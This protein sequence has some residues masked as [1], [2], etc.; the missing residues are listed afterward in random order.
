MA[1][2]GKIVPVEDIVTQYQGRWVAIQ[3]LLTHQKCLG[4][5]ART[6]LNCIVKLQASCPSNFRLAAMARTE[7]YPAVSKKNFH[8]KGFGW[9]TWIRTKINGVRVRCSTIELFP[10]S[11]RAL[12][13]P[14]VKAG[15]L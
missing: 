12:D 13:A 2:L 5:P 15:P 11:R 10:N 6:W 1:K 14:A 7:A 3:E 4:K 8:E 9:E